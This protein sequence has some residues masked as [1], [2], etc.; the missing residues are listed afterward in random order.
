MHKQTYR[1]VC[2]C[3]TAH[4]GLTSKRAALATLRQWA[5]RHIHAAMNDRSTRRRVLQLYSVKPG[6]KRGR[7]MY[8][9]RWR[10]R[11]KRFVGEAR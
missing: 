11:F 6:Q 7:L 1:I 8:R 9:L 3:G 4:R 2:V 5:S 10:P